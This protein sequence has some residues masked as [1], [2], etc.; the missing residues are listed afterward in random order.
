MVPYHSVADPDQ[1]GFNLTHPRKK[2]DKCSQQDAKPM[3][4]KSSFL[5]LP[6]YPLM[7]LQ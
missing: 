6:N 2:Q 1:I 5:D 4:D 3:N 7:R